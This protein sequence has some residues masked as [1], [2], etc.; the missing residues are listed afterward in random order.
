VVKDR[1]S[2]GPSAINFAMSSPKAS[3]ASCNIA[4]TSGRSEI[5]FSIP[6]DW[7]PW[8][9]NTNAN[10]MSLIYKIMKRE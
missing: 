4:R 9:G 2:A 5:E 7:E 6:T 8:P 1:A 10:V 3:E